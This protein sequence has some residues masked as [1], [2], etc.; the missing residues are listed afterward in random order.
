MSLDIFNFRKVEVLLLNETQSFKQCSTYGTDP[1][2]NRY[3]RKCFRE[4]S[5]LPILDRYSQLR[6][7]NSVRGFP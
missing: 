3:Y 7:E 1:V 5:V 4:K 6:T 2:P